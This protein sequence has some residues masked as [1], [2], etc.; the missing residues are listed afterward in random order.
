M[1]Y[2]TKRVL[3]SFAGFVIVSSAGFYGANSFMLYL[4]RRVRSA[5]L[6]KKVEEN[7][8]DNQQKHEFIVRPT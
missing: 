6:E 7:G 5:P 4:D 3:P 2:F 8:E 1:E